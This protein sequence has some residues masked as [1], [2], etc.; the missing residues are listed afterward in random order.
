MGARSNYVNVERGYKIL[1]L[2]TLTKSELNTVGSPWGVLLSS[3]V[4]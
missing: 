4:G 3:Q 2:N 1:W